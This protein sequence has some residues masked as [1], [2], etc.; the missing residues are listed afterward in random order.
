MPNDI[1]SLSDFFQFSLSRIK[2]DF[3]WFTGIQILISILILAIPLAFG[4]FFNVIWPNKDL[5][6]LYQLVALLVINIWVISLCRISQAVAG[7]R[8]RFKLSAVTEPAIWDKILRLP[9][10]IYRRFSAGELSFRASLIFDVQNTL[11]HGLLLLIAGISIL[12]MTL[13]LL[14]YYSAV[15]TLAGIA[16]AAVMTLA[17]V[18]VNYRQLQFMR[19]LYYHFGRF[20]GFTFELIAG[21][22]KIRVT[23]AMSRV[24]SLWVNR[25]AKRS[26]AEEK[27]KFYALELEVLVAFITIS[28]SAL[29][30]G[31]TLWSNINLTFGDFI[32]FFT[33][34][35]LFFITLLSMFTDLGDIAKSIPLWRRSR[36]ILTMKPEY[37][38]GKIDPG[39]LTGDIALNNIVFRYHPY[40]H[41]LF[42]NLSLHIQPGEFVAVVGPSGSGKSTLFRLILGFEKPEAG[43]IYFNGLNLQTLKILAVRRQ[44]GVVIQ[45][46]SLIPGTIFAKYCRPRSTNE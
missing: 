22:S 7:M 36:I 27:L 41:A 5:L 8:M 39:K 23:N 32:A 26:Y 3:W 29:L 16:L 19:S 21:I 30:F 13:I 25:L 10:R 33:S 6:M 28:S 31:L 9:L 24:F 20:I 4:Y 40:E 18:W 2:T 14:I 44:I 15:L 42:A 35:S 12:V 46:S 11:I 38:K 17:T 37:E 1:R 34:Y 45:N 43:E